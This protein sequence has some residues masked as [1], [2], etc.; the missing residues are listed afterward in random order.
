I[1]RPHWALGALKM[2]FACAA[3]T[4]R[5]LANGVA[6]GG[7]VVEWAGAVVPVGD[8]PPETFGLGLDRGQQGWLVEAG[9]A[10]A[11]EQRLAVDDD[12]LHVASAATLDQRLDRVVDSAVMGL[13]QIDDDN[14]GLRAR[15]QPPEVVAAEQLRTTQGGGVE[16]VARAADPEALVG[17]TAHQPG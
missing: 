15:R 17:L 7:D 1:I 14:V 2:L 16:H 9:W 10:A 8:E 3:T 4:A 6:Q 11:L 5:S 12:R 13:R